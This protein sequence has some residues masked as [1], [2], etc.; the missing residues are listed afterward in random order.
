MKWHGVAWH[1]D[2]AMLRWWM[3]RRKAKVFQSNGYGSRAAFG[4]VGGLGGLSNA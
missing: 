2:V 3:R 1:G 4:G